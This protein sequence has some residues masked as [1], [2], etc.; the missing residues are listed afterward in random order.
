MGIKEAADIARKELQKPKGFPNKV[1]MDLRAGDR[2]LKPDEFWE[3]EFVSQ[4]VRSLSKRAFPTEEEAR[5]HFDAIA[6][7]ILLRKKH[8]PN[9]TLAMERVF[10]KY[11]AFIP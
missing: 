10:E 8:E 3:K 7:N 11:A 4:L 5:E 9:D 6:E 2:Q 1:L